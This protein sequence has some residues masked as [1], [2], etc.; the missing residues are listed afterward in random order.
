[1]EPYDRTTKKEQHMLMRILAQHQEQDTLRS[2]KVEKGPN[3]FVRSEKT[4]ERWSKILHDRIHAGML[5]YDTT[6]R[7]KSGP[8]PNLAI[9]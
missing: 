6:R 2:S 5:V 8:K 9:S 7:R 1:M 3:V 4:K